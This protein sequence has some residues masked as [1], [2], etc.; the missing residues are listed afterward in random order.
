MTIRDDGAGG[1][2]PA[3]GSGLSLLLQCVHDCGGTLS[4]NSPVGGGTTIVVVIPTVS[5]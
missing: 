5:L 1:A 2:D 3:R 4:I